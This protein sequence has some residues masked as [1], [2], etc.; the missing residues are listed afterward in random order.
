MR[1]CRL[2]GVSKPTA[3]YGKN[4][5][6]KDGLFRE[7]KECVNAKNRERA[8]NRR[9]KRISSNLDPYLSKELKKCTGCELELN[10]TE[11][12]LGMSYPDGLQKRCK[13][14]SASYRNHYKSRIPKDPYKEVEGKVCRG[15]E[16]NLPSGHFNLHST[17]PDGL[18]VRCKSCIS[19]ADRER[20]RENQKNN[21][22]P[23]NESTVVEKKC[24]SCL[25]TKPRGEF[26][27]DTS[28]K[29]GIASQCKDCA[30]AYR[31]AERARYRTKNLT[32]D[33]YENPEPKRCINC[34]ETKGRDQFTISVV[35]GDGLN[36]KCHICSKQESSER[37]AR[38]RI[39]TISKVAFTDIVSRDEGICQYC[40]CDTGQGFEIDHVFPLH[41][42]GLHTEHN[43]VVA[44]VDCNR[45]KGGKDPRRFIENLQEDSLGPSLLNALRL[46]DDESTRSL[47]VS[48]DYM[49]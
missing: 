23:Q 21:S 29:S 37:R 6:Y 25:V 38:I 31:I 39:G 27:V 40:G 14:C 7:C 3:E 16:K 34:K 15:C 28:K 2:C 36:P 18:Q 8:S 17:T 9:L 30:R 22:S 12:S 45:S 33:P 13:K 20:V 35:R 46:Y 11:F 26:F 49:S 5:K 19:I 24:S 41:R 1:T 10:R 47:V 32:T 44:C 43:L 42:G 48:V 4:S